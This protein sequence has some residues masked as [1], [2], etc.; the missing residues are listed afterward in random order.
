[1]LPFAGGEYDGV[2]VLRRDGFVRTVVVGSGVFGGGTA[3]ASDGADPCVVHRCR[4]VRQV[5]S[6]LTARRLRARRA[7]EGGDEEEEPGDAP[8]RFVHGLPYLLAYTVRATFFAAIGVVVA[9][10]ADGDAGPGAPRARS[11]AVGEIRILQPVA[12][13]AEVGVLETRTAVAQLT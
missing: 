12:A 6:R 7:R 4:V 9:R 8:R 1:A 2:R 11:A 3:V 5:G 13:G 10:I